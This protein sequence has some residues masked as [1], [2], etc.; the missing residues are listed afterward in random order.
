MN[1]N[2][3]MIAKTM[4][5]FEEILAAELKELGAEDITSGNRMVTFTGDKAL[6]YKV[7]IASRVALKVLKPIHQFQAKDEKSYYE[8]IQYLDWSQIIDVK[9]SFAVDSRV[10]SKYFNHSHYVSLKAKDAIVDQFRDSLNLRPNVD[11]KT[12][13]IP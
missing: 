11:S 6:M 8:G 7:N 9:Q 1:D 4:F 10:D 3:E 12:P 13:N 5:G 2:Y